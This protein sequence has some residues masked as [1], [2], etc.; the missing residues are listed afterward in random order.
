M[1]KIQPKFLFILLITLLF[2]L[3]LFSQ[4]IDSLKDNYVDNLIE[5]FF[6]KELESQEIVDECINELLYLK[7]N[8]IDINKATEQQLKAFPF[9]NQDQ[10]DNIIEYRKKYG[11]I[12]SIYELLYIDGFNLEVVNKLSPFVK[13]SKI[14]E[15]FKITNKFSLD[16]YSSALVNPD[17]QGLYKDSTW[18]SN[19]FKNLFKL[20]YNSNRIIIAFKGEKDGGEAFFSKSNKKGY[21]FYSG[22]I[23]VFSGKIIKRLIIG[24][25]QLKCGQ[26]LTLWN[27]FNINKS[28]YNSELIKY[29]KNLVAYNNMNEN[30]FFRGIA[31]ESNYRNFQSILFISKKYFDA[32]IETIDSTNEKYITSLVFTGLHRSSSEIETENKANINAYGMRLKYRGNFY[33][34][35]TTLLS[36]NFNL[37]YL[38]KSDLYNYF[39]FRGKNLFKSGFD[40]NINTKIVDFFVEVS[41]NNNKVAYIVGLTSLNEHGLVFSMALRNY[42]AGFNTIFA[43]PISEFSKFDN[44]KGL[45]FSFKIPIN[46]FM[47]RGYTDLF[48]SKW[49]RYLINSPT[50]GKDLAIQ[51]DYK[52]WEE[53]LLNIRF[54]YCD[55]SNYYNRTNDVIPFS[56]NVKN[57]SIKLNSSIFINKALELKNSFLYNYFITKENLSIKNFLFSN[58]YSFSFNN[59]RNQIIT[60]FVYHLINNFFSKVYF[61]EPTL[62]LNSGFKTYSGNGIKLFF[63]FKIKHFKNWKFYFKYSQSPSYQNSMHLFEFILSYSN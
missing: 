45:I 3:N 26:G 48:Y 8:P 6:D 37:P 28:V 39:V 16:I 12:K 42:P 33:Q 2:Y 44:E 21:D 34:I 63:I 24:D 56:Y 59:N 1:N 30:N 25:Y 62:Y 31:L 7:D 13:I 52:F 23:E 57:Y 43:N 47:I 49:L 17:F 60:G 11:F 14:N 41:N 40:I 38:P 19:S 35:G 58:F 61:Y 5:E 18:E 22:Y 4:K 20:K 10:V 36:Y 53:N 32:Y 46:K 55:K 50:F 15:D 29:D 27:G 54:A 51:F 9:L